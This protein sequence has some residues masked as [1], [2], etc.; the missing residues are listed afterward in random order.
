MKTFT[1]TERYDVQIV[2]RYHFL[3]RHRGRGWQRSVS[4]GRVKGRKR[5]GFSSTEHETVADNGVVY[6]SKS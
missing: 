1:R 3:A 6:A 4:R 2:L 5:N